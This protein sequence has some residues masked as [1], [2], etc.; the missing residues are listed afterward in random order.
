MA[1][2]R[3]DSRLGEANEIFL[4]QAAEASSSRS[5]PRRK[6]SVNAIESLRFLRCGADILVEM[7]TVMHACE[8]EMVCESINPKIPYFNAPI[9]LENKV[10]YHELRYVYPVAFLKLKSHNRLPLARSTKSWV[11]S[12]RSTSPSS[13][14]RAL[15]QHPS[16]PVTR[17]SLVVISCFPWRSA[18][19][20]SSSN[21]C[22]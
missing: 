11:R 22:A 1:L 14:K 2:R 9:Y 15:S 3:C 7:G 20:Q 18:L 10:R 12:T 19:V 5:V 13:P 4:V 6:F 16:S 21:S 17:C 8:G